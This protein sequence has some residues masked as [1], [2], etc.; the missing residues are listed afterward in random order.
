M[1]DLYDDPRA[2][3]YDIRIWVWKEPWKLWDLHNV[4]LHVSLYGKL[5]ICND[6][7]VEGLFL[8]INYKYQMLYYPTHIVDG[9]L[10]MTS[11]QLYP[12]KDTAYVNNCQEGVSGN[13]TGRG[14]E[15]R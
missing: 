5:K 1:A 2:A 9:E 13:R 10:Q 8:D 6:P 11:L 4:D 15:V 3:L 14:K 7:R 12:K